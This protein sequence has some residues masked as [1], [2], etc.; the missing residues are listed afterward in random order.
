MGPT[1]FI[2]IIE[3]PYFEERRSLSVIHIILP[4]IYVY[5][6]FLT[7]LCL[8]IYFFGSVPGWRKWNLLGMPL[9]DETFAFPFCSFLRLE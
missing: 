8:F 5:K 3:I 4:F 7:M 9:R 1:D 2:I 6:I